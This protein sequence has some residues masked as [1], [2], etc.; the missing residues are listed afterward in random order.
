MLIKLT[1][2]AAKRVLA[3][4]GNINDP[5][6]RLRMSVEKGGCSGLEYAMSFDLKKEGD[7]EIESLG[8]SILVASESL[9]Y[10]KGS[11]VDF[12]DGL[13]GKGFEVRNPN[14]NTTCGCGRS[15]Q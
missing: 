8:V 3:L 10:L 2:R 1:E 9:E 5:E 14:A 12:D 6:K 13:N 11:E 15:F 4:T 7:T